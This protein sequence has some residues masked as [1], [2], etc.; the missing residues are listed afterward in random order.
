MGAVLP[1]CV[2]VPRPAP[3]TRQKRSHAAAAASASA[4]PVVTLP[5]RHKY[6]MTKQF[7]PAEETAWDAMSPVRHLPAL[8][9]GLRR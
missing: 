6:N 9:C 3:L 4:P 8:I 1:L 7:S 2:G 5:L